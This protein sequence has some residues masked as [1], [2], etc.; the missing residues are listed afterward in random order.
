MAKFERWVNNPYKRKIGPQSMD[1]EY[2]AYRKEVMRIR[3]IANKRIGRSKA[4]GF[5]NI[6]IQMDRRVPMSN[7]EFKGLSK[8]EKSVELQ[9]IKSRTKDMWNF[10]DLSTST[11]GG[12]KSM[13]D[14]II[15]TGKLGMMKF[16]G[17]Q[18]LSYSV[19]FK[20]IQSRIEANLAGMTAF[21][22]TQ[23]LF[24]EIDAD[25]ELTDDEKRDIKEYIRALLEGEYF[26]YDQAYY[27]TIDEIKRML[28]EI[29]DKMNNLRLQIDT[30]GEIDTSVLD[31]I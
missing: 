26:D 2:E 27:F 7:R 16:E 30:S 29:K 1:K 4:Q 13:V 28:P 22:K 15:K 14:D 8:A 21:D 20:V 11:V 5:D 3:D 31:I 6:L 19:A 23:R 12:F 9:K 10:M 18:G 24:D 25:P 17:L